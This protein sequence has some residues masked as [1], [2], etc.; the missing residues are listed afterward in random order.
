MGE[1]DA[2]GRKKMT[3]KDIIALKRALD[4]AEVPEDGRRLVL[5]P[6][7]VNDLLE[8]DQ[9][10][11]DKYY[12][13][14]SGKLLNMFGFQIYTFINCPYFYQRGS[15]GTVYSGTGRN[16]HEGILCV[17]CTPHVPCARFYEDVLQRSCDQSDRSG[18]PGK[19]PPLLYRA[20]EETGSDWSH[21]FV[22][23]TTAQSK[24]QTAPAEKRWAQVRREAAAA[25][26][27]EA[28]ERRWATIGTRGRRS[29]VITS[30]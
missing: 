29:R 17:L 24:E 22:D 13:Y 7:H 27:A 30:H 9:S 3:L 19:L 15:Q 16:R 1:A 6:D 26:A 4:N 21:L 10:F 14:T 5:C 18:E 23:G 2:A 20:A 28:R 8:Q 11:K 25:K 12:N